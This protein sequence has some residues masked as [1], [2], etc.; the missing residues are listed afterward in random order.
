MPL[1]KNSQY[2]PELFFKNKHFNTLYR[3]FKTNT[4]IDF[5]TERIKTLDQDFV[6]L[7]ISSVG[8]KKAIV[9]IHG[10]EGSS[11][12]SYIRSLTRVA[13]HNDFDVIAMNLRGCS[14]VPNLLLKSY[15]SGKTSD[16]LEVIQYIE[17]KHIYTEIHIVGYS[18]GGNITLKFMGE[19]SNELPKII[20]SAVGIS[21]PCDLEGGIIELNQFSNSLYQFGFL[22]TLKEKAKHRYKKRPSATINLKKV[23]NAKNL[24]AFDEYFTAPLNGFKNAIDYYTQSSCK[25]FIKDIKMPSLLISALDDPFLSESCYPFA[26]AEKNDNFYLL[27]PKYGGH[28][29]FF[30]SFNKNKNYW[31]ENQ[32]LKFIQKNHPD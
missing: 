24:M 28:V 27:T 12:S 6:D 32:I 9:A 18:L 3:Y 14:G 2:K 19:S 20:K 15:H 31:L 4:Q 5:K 16:L 10:L 25:Q 30:S 13:N 29:G 11:N 23:V 1:I 7:D 21:T 17:R 22:K 26:E 8:S